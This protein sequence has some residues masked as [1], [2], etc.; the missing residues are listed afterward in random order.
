MAKV[1]ID[2]PKTF[3]FSTVMP[4][5]IQH[6]NRADH[7]ANEHLI[8]LLN[9]ARTRYYSKISEKNGFN[10]KE[11]IN[12]DLAVIY[13]S[14]AH[15]GDHLSI[16]IAANDFN[17]YG[18]DLVYKVSQADGGQLV[19]LAKMAMLR[20]DKNTHKLREVSQDFADYFSQ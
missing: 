13:K 11:F 4:V 15:Y 9:E 19:A 8:A 2:V 1:T 12:A 20:I 3:A 6:I 14:E 18:C 16:E 7:L 17:K 5:L 10:Y